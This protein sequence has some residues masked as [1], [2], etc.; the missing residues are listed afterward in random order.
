MKQV[1]AEGPLT[2]ASHCLTQP[3]IRTQNIKTITEPELSLWASYFTALGTLSPSTELAYVATACWKFFTNILGVPR[4]HIVFRASS[5][6][7]DLL[8][9]TRGIDHGPVLELDGYELRRFRHVFGVPGVTGRNINIAIT[10][11][12]WGLRD[13]GNIIL[14]ERGKTPLA[15]ELAFGTGTVLSRLHGLYHPL[16]A[17]AVGMAIPLSSSWDFKLADTLAVCVALAREGLRPNGSNRGRILR[18]HLQAL[19]YLRSRA[20][21]SIVELSD[22]AVS[23]ENLEFGIESDLSIRFHNYLDTFEQTLLSDLPSPL[24]NK[25]ALAAFNECDLVHE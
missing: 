20:G 23:F 14:I 21:R 9:A 3:A 24:R 22:F 12:R 25:V 5:L 17:S 8:S 6:D 10:S 13:I 19:S 15:L 2:G 7:D 1:L 18:E 16:Q 11:P 4:S